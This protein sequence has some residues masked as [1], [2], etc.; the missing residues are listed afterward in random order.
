MDNQKL[1]SYSKKFPIDSIGN[2]LVTDFITGRKS[3]VAHPYVYPL[4]GEFKSNWILAWLEENTNCNCKWSLNFEPLCW[5]TCWSTYWVPVETKHFCMFF[6][7]Y[8]QEKPGHL[9]VKHAGTVGYMTP[10]LVKH[11]QFDHTA[12]LFSFGVFLY[13]CLTGR[14]DF[15]IFNLLF[16]TTVISPLCQTKNLLQFSVEVSLLDYMYMLC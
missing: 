14:S 5:E 6:L 7:T 1:V 8:R 16:Y 11:Q 9:L 12:D 4:N 3:A 15:F 10:E 13:E 2:F